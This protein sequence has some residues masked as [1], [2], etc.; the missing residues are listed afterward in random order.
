MKTRLKNPVPPSYSTFVNHTTTR[1]GVF[2]VGGNNTLAERDLA[3]TG[4]TSTFGRSSNSQM[5]TGINGTGDTFK[6]AISYGIAPY[7]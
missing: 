1:P 2:N 7:K 3:H 4:F 5:E 6:G